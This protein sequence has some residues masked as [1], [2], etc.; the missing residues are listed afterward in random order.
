MHTLCL[1]GHAS[2]TIKSSTRFLSRCWY[3]KLWRSFGL[4]HV[5]GIFREGREIWHLSF[6]YWSIQFA[7]IIFPMSVSTNV[8]PTLWQSYWQKSTKSG[9]SITKSTNVDIETNIGW[10]EQPWSVPAIHACLGLEAWHYARYY[11]SVCWLW[12]K[13]ISYI[14]SCS[15][16]CYCKASLYG[17]IVMWWL[18]TVIT[19]KSTPASRILFPPPGY[20][21]CKFST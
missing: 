7:P 8:H 17:F 4:Y 15:M 11:K 21:R 6:N 2:H 5:I 10:P 19:I 12:Y 3:I 1:K 14:S 13:T 20:H 16:L 9:G 18:T